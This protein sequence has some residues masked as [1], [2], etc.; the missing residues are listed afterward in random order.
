MA[1]FFEKQKNKLVR[2]NLVQKANRNSRTKHFPSYSTREKKLTNVQQEWGL[3]ES[4]H[5]SKL[6][7][8]S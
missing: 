6:N 5:K 7:T 1:S 4:I 8:E 2:A 3:Y